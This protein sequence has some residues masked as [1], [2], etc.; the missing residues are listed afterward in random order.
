MTRKLGKVIMSVLG[1]LRQEDCE[2]EA[3]L[4]HIIVSCLCKPNQDKNTNESTKL[5]KM[6]EGK[7]LHHH[8]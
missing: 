6:T 7:S 5:K 4:S 8:T 3:S 1:S 2:S